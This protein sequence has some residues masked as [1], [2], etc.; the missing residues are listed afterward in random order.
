MVIR[1][2]ALFLLFAIAFYPFTAPAATAASVAKDSRLEGV[3]D[4]QKLALSMELKTFSVGSKSARTDALSR[5]LLREAGWIPNKDGLFTL[6]MS[7]S[8]LTF[9]GDEQLG[10]FYV[11]PFTRYVIPEKRP[12]PAMA[13]SY[14]VV[15][16]NLDY[17]NYAKISG[18]GYIGRG[19]HTKGD[20]YGILP[21]NQDFIRLLAHDKITSYIFT[22]TKMDVPAAQKKRYDYEL[23]L[24]CRFTDKAQDYIRRQANIKTSS[25]RSTNS[26][27]IMEYLLCVD[28][29]GAFVYDRVAGKVL[30]EWRID[31]S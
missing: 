28:V 23:Y 6:K 20:R 13:G 2:I 16:E 22:L 9:R 21:F 7:N 26:R 10:N 4:I 8:M 5:E 31:P 17:A 27:R 14:L 19:S 1:R 29:V 15:V 30:C 25:V 12:R 24:K 3:V 11:L 18:F